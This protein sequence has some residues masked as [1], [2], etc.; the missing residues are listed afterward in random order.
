MGTN[1]FAAVAEFWSPLAMKIYIV[2]MVLA[3]I[4]GTIFDVS[5]KGSGI[6]FAQRREKSKARARRQIN[7]GEAFALAVATIAEAAVSGE[8]DKTP[9]RIAHLLTMYGFVLN[10]ITT[11]LMVFAYPTAA[12]TPPIVS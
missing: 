11:A 9:R 10:M 6:Y 4:V 12:A 2:L 5:H 3:V 1:P 7:G 8:F